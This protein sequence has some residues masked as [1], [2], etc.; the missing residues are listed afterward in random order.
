METQPLVM[1]RSYNAP[2]KKVWDAITNAEQMRQWYFDIQAFEPVPG[3]KFSF[4]CIM[5]DNKEYTHLCEVTEAQEDKK[6][7]YSWRYEGYEGN[8]FVTFELFPEG[9][10]IKLV[11]THRGLDTFPPLNEFRRDC[12]VEGWTDLLGKSLKEYVENV[13]VKQ[14]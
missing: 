8:S 7:T 11:L 3:Y 5:E 1:E 4:T 2:V 10:G 14:S 6:L 12:F 13:T 9:E